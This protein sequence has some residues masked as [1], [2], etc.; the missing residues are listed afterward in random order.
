VVHEYT[1]VR[2]S[3]DGI[4]L[5]SRQT[6]RLARVT[7]VTGWRRQRVQQAASPACQC[8]ATAS[9]RVARMGGLFPVQG[10]VVYISWPHGVLLCSVVM[11]SCIHDATP[12][13][14]DPPT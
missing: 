1:V 9:L 11:Y 14:P 5:V 2:Y 10:H 13:G 4:R 6:V 8:A 12:D 3:T 7:R